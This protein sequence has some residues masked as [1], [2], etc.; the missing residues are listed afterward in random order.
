MSKRWFRGWNELPE[1]IKEDR[2]GNPHI[3]EAIE[4]PT[5]KVWY[6]IRGP[7]E[8]VDVLRIH[9]EHHPDFTNDAAG[10]QK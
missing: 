6:R 5:G 8:A 3:L 10:E 1:R 9:T 4:A 2:S 7:Q